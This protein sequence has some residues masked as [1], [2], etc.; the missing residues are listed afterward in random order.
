VTAFTAFRLYEGAERPDGRLVEMAVDELPPGEV[1]IRVAYSSINYK[2]ALAAAGINRIVRTFPRIGGIDFTGTVTGSRD[3]RFSEG[4]EVIVHGF[5]VGVDHDGG[6]AQYARVPGDWVMRL[7]RGL[8][9]LDAATLGAAGYTAGLSLHLMEL[10]GLAPHRGPVVVTGGT[11]GVASVAIDMLAQ[12]GYPVTAITGKATEQQYLRDLGASAILLR[13]ELEM[14]RRPL[15]KGLW[16]GAVDSVGGETL[17]WLTRTMQ[18]EG[19]ITSFGNAGGAEL[20]TT[21]MPF[22]L[23]GV[24]LIGVNGNSPMPL[25]EVVWR[26]I[27]GEYRPRCLRA[28]AHVIELGELPDAMARMLRSENRGRAVVRLW[29]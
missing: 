11:G 10:N 28:I 5:G 24:R 27:A 29:R 26:K 23:R 4:D 22:I 16:A 2:D 17:A 21:V 6:H 12:R 20:N 8:D 1:T 7:P 25:R 3:E 19:V 14:G 9:L 18:P 15:E 13:G